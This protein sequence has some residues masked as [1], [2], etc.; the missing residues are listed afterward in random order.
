[1]EG[2]SFI[3]RCFFALLTATNFYL[4][5]CKIYRNQRPPTGVAVTF[6]IEA[7]KSDRKRRKRSGF[8]AKIVV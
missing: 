4:P 3:W 6:S 8:T 5:F 7:V 2:Y 1:M